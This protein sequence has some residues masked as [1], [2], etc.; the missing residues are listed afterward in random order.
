MFFMHMMCVLF[1]YPSTKIFM[2]YNRE[3]FKVVS[4]IFYPISVICLWNPSE[5]WN[6]QTIF[7]FQG[8]YCIDFLLMNIFYAIINQ[9]NHYKLLNLFRLGLITCEF[10]KQRKHRFTF[11]PKYSFKMST[12][13]YS[14]TI[15]FFQSTYPY[16]F[17]ILHR[18]NYA[19]SLLPKPRA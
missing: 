13:I 19:K 14:S 15:F 16:P 17:I 4:V 6:L 10:S 2:E 5:E 7:W 18:Y 1:F 9:P 8:L 11:D 3:H 12:S